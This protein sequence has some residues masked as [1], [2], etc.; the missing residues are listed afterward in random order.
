MVEPK[1]T[2]NGANS[3]EKERKISEI[4]VISGRKER[5]RFE[6]PRI[7]EKI[8]SELVIFVLQ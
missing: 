1:L 7:I 5:D 3:R 4:R 6:T 2:A 8:H